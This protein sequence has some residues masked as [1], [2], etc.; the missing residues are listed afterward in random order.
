MLALYVFGSTTYAL[1]DFVVQSVKC[2]G[3]YSK[4]NT[5]ELADSFL[6]GGIMGPVNSLIP[7]PSGALAQ[8]AVDGLRAVASRFVYDKVSG[9]ETTTEGVV[10][11]YMTGFI[12]SIIGHAASDVIQTVKSPGTQNKENPLKN[13]EYTDKVKEQ[14]SKR[15][16]HAFPESVDAFG[17][18][19]VVT[20]ITGGDGVLRSKVE[21]GGSYRGKTGVFEYIIESNGTVNH[22]LFKPK[23]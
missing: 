23:N 13:T 22:R 11:A 16:Y 14:M 10:S 2:K 20:N 7:V 18:E 21:I 3:D 15:D 5:Q 19:G 12:F 6:T 9:Q 4:F 1:V 8:I 17:G